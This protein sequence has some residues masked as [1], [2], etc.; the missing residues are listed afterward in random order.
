MQLSPQQAECV[1]AVRRWLALPKGSRAPFFLIKG[2]AGCGKSALIPYATEGV[3]KVCH[4]APTGKAALVMKSYGCANARTIH[5]LIYTPKGSSGDESASKKLHAALDRRENDLSAMGLSAEE[6][7]EDEEIRKLRGQLKALKDKPLFARRDDSDLEEANLLVLSEASMITEGIARDLLSYGVPILCE[8]DGGQLPPIEGR[9]YFMH[10]A[11]KENTFELTQIHRQA[12][13]SPILEMARQARMTGNLDY[14]DY[15]SD[16]RVVSSISLEEALT[17]SQVL[18]GRNHTRHI[19]NWKTRQALGFVPSGSSAK[20]EF[21]PRPKEKLLCKRNDNDLGLLNGSFW[22]CNGAWEQD[23]KHVRID[24]TS[25]DGEETPHGLLCH[26][27]LLTGPTQRKLP[28]WESRSRGV[29]H[30]EFGYTVTVHSGQGSQWPSVLLIDDWHDR[31][32]ARRAWLYT[33]CTRAQQKL[34]VLR[35][36]DS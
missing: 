1:A 16:C 29:Q 25:E 36:K 23:D 11:R 9:A 18:C 33:A 14:G 4:A 30:I 2:L 27:E 7:V 26:K 12:E 10:N 24:M 32:Q 20:D 34:V 22:T 35:E 6:M 15:G 13:G 17:F 8:G 5:S 19:K 3:K 31:P 28:M 21:L